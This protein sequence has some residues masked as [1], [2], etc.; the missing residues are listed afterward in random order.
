MFHNVGGLNMLVLEKLNTNLI[1]RSISVT[2]VLFLGSLTTMT[3]A[4]TSLQS[5]GVTL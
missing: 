1:K 3:L 2:V 5:L 4:F